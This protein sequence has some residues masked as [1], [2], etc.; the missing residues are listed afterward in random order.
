MMDVAQTALVA[1]CFCQ[2]A[3]LSPF[4][5]RKMIV[6]VIPLTR[7]PRDRWLY[8]Y[9]I[10]DEHVGTVDCGT[11]VFVPFGKQQNVRAVVYELAQKSNFDTV[12]PINSV[13][14]TSLVPTHVIDYHIQLATRFAASPSALL[15]QVIPSIPKRSRK[16]S[17]RTTNDVDFSIKASHLEPIKQAVHSLSASEG[18]S[19]ISYQDIEDFLTLITYIYKKEDRS[20]VLCVPYK[21]MVSEFSEV[22]T[23]LGVQ[24]LDFTASGKNDYVRAWQRAGEAPYVYIGTKDILLMPLSDVARIFVFNEAESGYVEQ[25]QRIRLDIRTMLQVFREM[26]PV[27]VTWVGNVPSLES[28]AQLSSG[29]ISLIPLPKK[30]AA[31]LIVPMQDQSYDERAHGVAATTL[32]H[33]RNTLQK[34]QKV[35]L[36][37]N[38]KGISSQYVCDV[39]AH[40]VLCENCHTPVIRKFETLECTQCRKQYG[41]DSTCAYCS[42]GSYKEFGHRIGSYHRY[43]QAEF[44]DTSVVSIHADNADSVFDTLPNADIVIATKFLLHNMAY[45]DWKR[46]GFVAV[47]NAESFTVSSNYTTQETGYIALRTLVDQTQSVGALFCIQTY[48]EHSVLIESL[49]TGN[50]AAF[51]KNELQARRALSYPPYVQKVLCQASFR[52]KDQALSAG[53][54]MYERLIQNK[55]V[56]RDVKKSYVIFTK[57]RFTA[58]I[59]LTY[60]RGAKSHPELA[61]LEPAW[62]IAF[63]PE[64]L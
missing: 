20:L 23:A 55:T 1:V 47:L 36:F 13:E 48:T 59:V 3:P 58:K 8:D 57:G 35:L 63:N 39:C 27:P 31:P 4:S 10:S 34:G 16:E 41:L 32:Q 53:N 50:D 42:N 28:Y 9:E 19:Y 43:L 54:A 40:P 6:R 12:K 29:E 37:I 5:L 11:T 2:L 7:T 46:Y 60:E 26:H 30:F 61:V 15:K 51:Y 18:D 22:L 56:A 21:H 45:S 25:H 17:T 24:C 44:L 14:R 38:K 64:H 49:V 52:T 62:S 33:M